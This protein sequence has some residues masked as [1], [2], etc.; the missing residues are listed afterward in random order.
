ML[1]NGLGIAVGVIAVALALAPASVRADDKADAKVKQ[2]QAALDRAKAEIDAVRMRNSELENGRVELLIQAEVAKKDALRAQNEAK[3]A[4]AITEETAKKLEEALTR[5]A[6]LKQGGQVPPKPV[7]ALPAEVRGQVTNVSDD[8]VVLD[9]GVDAGLA[10]GTTL[11]VYRP[12]EKAPRYIGTVKV[13]SAL[14]LF[15]KQAIVTFT[16][17]RKV[18]FD[19]LRPEELPRKGDQVRPQLL[20]PKDEREKKNP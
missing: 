19:R 13:T 9:I 17:A 18:R 5:L 14:N 10:V 7:P 4:R 2:L 16:P 12:D 20:T 15:P 1:R 3:L 11:D 6:E 8:L